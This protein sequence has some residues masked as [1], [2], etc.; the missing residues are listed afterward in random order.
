MAIRPSGRE[1]SINYLL[2]KIPQDIN[3]NIANKYYPLICNTGKFAC[4]FFKLKLLYNK[5]IKI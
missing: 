1:V 5:H 4:E 3:K 2:N